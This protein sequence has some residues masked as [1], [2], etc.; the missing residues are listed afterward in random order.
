[1]KREFESDR[2]REVESH[3]GRKS[4]KVDIATEQKTIALF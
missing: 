2:V 1:V 3:R 4:E